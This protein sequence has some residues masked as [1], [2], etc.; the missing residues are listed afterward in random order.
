MGLERGKSILTEVFPGE[1]Q[2]EGVLKT[3]R[4]FVKEEEEGIPGRGTCKGGES[5]EQFKST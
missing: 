2:T 1:V 4:E 5:H 3:E